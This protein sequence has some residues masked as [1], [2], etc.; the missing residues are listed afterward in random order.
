MKVKTALRMPVHVDYVRWGPTWESMKF[1][2]QWLGESGV[3]F[4]FAAGEALF[5]DSEE[6]GL[7]P[8]VLY[9]A[10]FNGHEVRRGWYLVKTAPREVTPVSP[11]VWRRDYEEIEQ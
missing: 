4:R 11:A 9:D 2:A 10:H 3:L 5:D 7:P 6:Y 8:L 1:A